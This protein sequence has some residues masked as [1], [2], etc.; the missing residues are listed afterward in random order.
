MRSD[1]RGYAVHLA[2]HVHA[3]G[4]MRMHADACGFMG[5]LAC[6]APVPCTCEMRAVSYSLASSSSVRTASSRYTPPACMRAGVHACMHMCMHMQGVPACMC[7]RVH[8]CMCVDGCVG[9]REEVAR[10]THELTN[11]LTYSLTYPRTHVRTHLRTYSR[12]YSLTYRGQVARPT[13]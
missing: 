8:A 12:T 2:S 5:A 3:C 7:A 11:L 4:C 10:S 13:N 9:T 1:G 6:R